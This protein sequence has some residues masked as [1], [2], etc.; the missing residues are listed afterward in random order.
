MSSGTFCPTNTAPLG[1]IRQAQALDLLFLSPELAS[2]LC[3]TALAT[4]PFYKCMPAAQSGPDKLGG[5]A[6][7]ANGWRVGAASPLGLERTVI[8]ASSWAVHFQLGELTLVSHLLPGSAPTS[9]CSRT[10]LL[11]GQLQASLSCFLCI[12]TT[13]SLCVKRAVPISPAKGRTGSPT[14]CSLHLGDS[15]LGTHTL[16]ASVRVH[17]PGHRLM[18]SLES[19]TSWEEKLRSKQGSYFSPV[20]ILTA[21]CCT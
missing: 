13:S 16:L 1:R 2:L 11:A 12:G 18:G 6:G 15:E 7:L 9:V 4:L 21:T 14:L 10:G 19:S 20:C 5:C 17:S 8:Q 3:P